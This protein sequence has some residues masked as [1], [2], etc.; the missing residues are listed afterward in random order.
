VASQ[1][2]ELVPQPSPRPQRRK[3][4]P[5]RITARVLIHVVL[6]IGAITMLLPVLWMVATSLSSTMYAT[7]FP[8]QFF[9]TQL[10]PGNFVKVLSNPMLAQGLLNSVIVVVP[11]ILGQVICSSAGAFA[12]ARMRA[13]GKRF[14]FVLCISTMLI[15]VEVLLIPQF[16]EFKY[17]GWLNTL[18]PLIATQVFGNAYN[19]FLMRQFF[20]TIPLEYDEAARIDGLGFFGIWWRIILPLSTPVLTTIA[21]FSFTYNWGVLLTPMVFIHS[22]QSETLTQVLYNMSLTSNLEVVPPWNLIM[23]GSMLLTI[24]MVIV[25]FFAQRNIYETNVLGKV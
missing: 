8:P 21:V 17:L 15:P 2:V 3:I 1:S 10:F 5:G 20:M 14:L 25:Y 23:A 9:P 16:I 24:P 6:V 12:F 13:P 18:L 11:S 4:K 7:T 22:T 19:I